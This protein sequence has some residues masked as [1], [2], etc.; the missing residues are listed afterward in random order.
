MS[1]LSDYNLVLPQIPSEEE[2][3]EYVESLE[4]RERDISILRAKGYNLLADFDETSATYE[5][6]GWLSLWAK[7]MTALES[8]IPALHSGSNLILQSLS[9]ATFE[10]MQHQFTIT[11]PIHDLIEHIQTSREI[12]MTEYAYRSVV[13][14]LRAYTAW[15]L[16]S[17]KNYYQEII[18]PRTQ[19]NIWDSRPAREIFKNPEKL[20]CYEKFYGPLDSEIDDDKLKQGRRK[21]EALYREKIRRINDWLG[22]ITI[23]HWSKKL[24]ENNRSRTFSFFSLFEDNGKITKQLNK[25][26]L[27]FAYASYSEGSMALHGSTIEQFMFIGDS[28]VAPKIQVSNQVEENLLETVLFNCNHILVALAIIDQLILKKPGLRK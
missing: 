21:M 8:I 27:R 3:I 12:V 23:Q 16:W 10:W 18:D 20:Q 1:A 26:Q 19:K 2:W 25:Y 15:C 13:D 11:D 5:R 24:E 17:D 6:V 4:G 9:R 7:V 28:E 14:R 22:D